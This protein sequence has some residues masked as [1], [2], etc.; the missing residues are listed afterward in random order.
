MA[1]GLAINIGG[2]RPEGRATSI[3]ASVGGGPSCCCLVIHIPSSTLLTHNLLSPPATVAACSAT[4][5]HSVIFPARPQVVTLP[6]VC[7]A[8]RGGT[9]ARV[10]PCRTTSLLNAHLFDGVWACNV[11]RGREKK[12]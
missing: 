1:S 11:A 6:R 7:T 10:R 5:A 9:V 3:I 8:P 2:T 4:V 12:L